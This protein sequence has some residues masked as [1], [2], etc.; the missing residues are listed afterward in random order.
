[1]LIEAIKDYF[2]LNGE[3]LPVKDIHLL[4]RQL[5]PFV[6]EVIRVVDGIPLYIEEHI[7]RMKK[8]AKLAGN[9]LYMNSESIITNT[10]RL[11]E[12]NKCDNMNIKYM[13]GDMNKVIHSLSMFFINSYYPDE[14]VYKKGIH[15]TLLQ[16]EREKPNAKIV[17]NDFKKKAKEKMDKEKAFEAIL[18]NEKRYITEG[19]RSNIFFVKGKKIITAPANNVLLGVT[20]NKIFKVCEELGYEIEE[21]HVSVREL[22]SIDGAFMTG[23]SVNVLPITTID[24]IEY[25]SVNNDIIK[26]ISNGYIEDMNKY[27]N[28][29]RK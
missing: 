15:T 7:D 16:C 19:S 22:M 5:G 14:G 9:N 6:Y 26:N 25:D 13:L 12:A 11:I 2:I 17:S 4:N 24:H 27:I 21:R 3:I 1:M 18:V 8:S 28:D 20:R 29:K 10:Y 23:T